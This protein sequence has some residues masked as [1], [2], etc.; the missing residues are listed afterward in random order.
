MTFEL[1]TLIATALET[2]PY[3]A[4]HDLLKYLIAAA[5]MALALRLAPGAWV[6]LRRL[7]VRLP[8][9]EDIR[10]ELL[11]ST[12]TVLVFSV[13]STAIVLGAE[14]GLFRVYRDIADFGWAYFLASIALLIVAHDTYFYWTHRLMH[15]RY[16][17]RFF[18]RVHHLS[19]APTPWAAY[20]F[21]PAEAVVQAAFLPLALLV[22]PAHWTAIFL[23]AL[24]MIVR[25]VL[26][27]SGVSVEPA[28]LLRGWW[29]RWMT[30][31]AHHDLHHERGR[32]NYGL[33]FAWWDRLMGTEHPD[34]RARLREIS[35][36]AER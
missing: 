22:F 32:Y 33:Y 34:Y 26:G 7:Q 21:A 27:H 29:G 2:W 17:F 4:L 14:H 8:G 12:L 31:T 30:T 23:F 24:H 11:Y 35:T 25:N 10:R 28:R 18:H 1:P 15:S 9:A 5:S 16:L 13:I 36:R 20:A 3:L 6:A 19:R